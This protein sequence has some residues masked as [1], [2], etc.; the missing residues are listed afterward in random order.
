MMTS[1]ALAV[2]GGKEMPVSG[3]LYREDIEEVRRR[4]TTWWNNGDIGRPAM[5]ITV[6]RGELRKC[7]LSPMP[8]PE[9]W[10]THYSTSNFEYRVNSQARSFLDHDRLAEHVPDTSADLAPNCLALYLGCRGVEMPG[11]VWCEP[12]IDRPEEAV[13]EYDADNFYWDFTLRLTR[14]LLD[15]GQGRFL[16]SFPDLIEG[17]D[18]LAAMYGAERL[19]LELI[20]RP[21]W[22]RACLRQITDRYFHYYDILY[23]M[24]RDEV[25]GSSFWAW[26]PGRMTKL[27]CDFSAMISS[28]MFGEFMVPVLREMTERVSYSMYHWD[29]PGAIKHLDHL[30][31][32]PKLD[33]IQWTP[34]A[35]QPPPDHE[36]WWPLYHR[37]IAA[38]KKV[39]CTSCAGEESLK[40]MRTEFG[41]GL[42]HFL[43]AMSAES[44]RQ[45]DNILEIARG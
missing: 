34:G 13:F 17:L 33:M 11:T 45:A 41:P 43:I 3:L 5:Q 24:I 16:V 10:L 31:G 4:L 6:K 38:G 18:T 26:A 30:L 37:I 9:G 25:G 7:D 1:A 27:Q 44:P 28:E 12:C 14:G 29:G 8:E 40:A 39:Y 36:R 23:D 19:L 35:G 22:I 2:G 15:L 21:D 32:L 42:R 20:D